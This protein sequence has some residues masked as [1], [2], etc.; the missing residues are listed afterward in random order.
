MDADE[1]IESDSEK[2]RQLAFHIRNYTTEILNIC[3]FL[4]GGMAHLR[5][6]S[7]EIRE[8]FTHE[9]YSEWEHKL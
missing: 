3:V 8:F 2:M 7:M 1:L 4:V 9:S 5:K 6:V